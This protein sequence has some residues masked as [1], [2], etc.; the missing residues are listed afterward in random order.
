MQC[1]IHNSRLVQP[2]L[3]VQRADTDAA[4]GLHRMVNAVKLRSDEGGVLLTSNRADRLNQ[5]FV[6]Y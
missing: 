5:T 1:N 3:T 6:T 4:A 2:A